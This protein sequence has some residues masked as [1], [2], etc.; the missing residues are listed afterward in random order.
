MIV[1]Q[2]LVVNLVVLVAL[3]EL[4]TFI[5]EEHIS[6]LY[7]GFQFLWLYLDDQRSE[8]SWLQLGQTLAVNTRLRS[9]LSGIS[10]GCIVKIWSAR[11]EHT[12]NSRKLS[13][14]FSPSKQAFSTVSMIDA[15][16]LLHLHVA[17]RLT[18]AVRLRRNSVVNIT[19][20]IE[21]WVVAK[22]G[23]V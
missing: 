10:H 22:F 15:V 1:N 17:C 7:R 18:S 20:R 9:S 21:F 11:C 16:H 23:I 6:H 14:A 13:V 12:L 8:G 3:V 5:N 2:V 19:I 4:E